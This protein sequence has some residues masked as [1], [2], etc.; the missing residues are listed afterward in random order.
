MVHPF[1]S[2]TN[3]FHY[4]RQLPPYHYIVMGGQFGS[5]PF[6]MSPTTESS[7]SVLI[8]IRSMY[9]SLPQLIQICMGTDFDTVSQQTALS[10]RYDHRD[11][12][13]SNVLGMTALH[14]LC[15]N[16]H[17]TPEVVVQCFRMY[18]NSL[19]MKDVFDKTPLEWLLYL[20]RM[21]VIVALVTDIILVL[22]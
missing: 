7:K 5:D 17:S 8:A 18:T 14:I 4:W 15:V 1:E 22:K 16:E 10:T 21:D 3:L 2:C 20:R 11:F 13:W 12:Q 9:F 19:V 6:N